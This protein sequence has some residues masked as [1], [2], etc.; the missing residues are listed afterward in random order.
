[1]VGAW[2]LCLARVRAGSREA[3]AELLYLFMVAVERIPRNFDL[4]RNLC[5]VSTRE[6]ATVFSAIRTRCFRSSPSG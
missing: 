5:R 6:T 3:F 2:Q 1:M 4:R